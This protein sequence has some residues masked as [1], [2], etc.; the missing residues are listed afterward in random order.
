M[1]VW[2]QQLNR[3]ELRQTPGDNEGQRRLVC[4]VHGVAKCQAPPATE[5]HKECVQFNQVI[6]LRTNRIYFPFRQGFPCN[7]AGKETAC[8]A[9]DLDF[10]SGL[11]RSSGER[12]GY[13]LQYS[14]PENSMDC[15]VHGVTKSQTQLSKFYFLSFCMFIEILSKERVKD[16]TL[17][18]A[19]C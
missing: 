12:K 18:N 7:S 3:H 15:I 16:S 13:P 11:G 6:Y 4:S 10:I 2:Y 19:K 1:V 5:Q 14:C 8:N 17:E 9:G